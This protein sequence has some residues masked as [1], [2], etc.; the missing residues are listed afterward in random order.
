MSICCRSEASGH[1]IDVQQGALLHHFAILD[2]FKTNRNQSKK[3]GGCIAS[4]LQETLQAFTAEDARSD[5]TDESNSNNGKADLGESYDDASSTDQANRNSLTTVS[6]TLSVTMLLLDPSA[7]HAWLRLCRLVSCL[8][9]WKMRKHGHGVLGSVSENLRWVYIKVKEQLL[10]I[11]GI[12]MWDFDIV[13][14][15]Q[16]TGQS[17][18]NFILPASIWLLS[19]AIRNVYWQG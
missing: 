3:K 4:V 7:T 15:I 9:A 11:V 2:Q 14:A 8:N 13:S 10:A 5:F 16:M 19:W 17:C 12:D 1:V 18:F 6:S